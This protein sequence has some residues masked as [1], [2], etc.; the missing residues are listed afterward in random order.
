MVHHRIPFRFLLLAA[1]GAALPLQAHAD[2]PDSKLK[3]SG[4]LSIVGGRIVGSS[5]G[6][7]YVG[8][9]AID[10]KL[11]PCY[12]ADWSYAGAYRKT[13]SLEPETRAGIQLK[14]TVS[15]DLNLVTQIVT[16]ATDPKPSVQ[17]AYGSYAI[18]KQWEV[19]LGRKRIPLYFYS[20][21]QDVGVAYPW[22]GVPPELYGWEVTNYNGAS[23]RFKTSLG[24]TNIS[25]S[26]FAG[27]ETVKDALY[28]RLYYDSPTKVSWSKLVGGD[29]EVVH[30]VLTTR[31]VYM[32]SDVRTIN[33]HEALDD[34]AALKAYGLAANLDFEDWFV[35]AELTQ[36]TRDFD[37]GYKVTAPAFTVG[38]GYRW[39]N[40]TPFINVARY[41]EKSSDLAVYAPQSYDRAS[42]T[43]RYD[44]DARSAL[45]FQVDRNKD[46][47]RNF[48]G[49]TTILRLAY[50]RLF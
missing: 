26:M 42:L 5:L 37:S 30:G 3:V 21:Y 23:V 12:T 1:L 11:C 41:K 20:D 17:W 46:V 15:R 13:S 29:V 2:D 9:E 36:L 6:A 45:K 14:Y 16:R 25:A 39:G 44:V 32:Q 47:T 34:T 19:Q 24:D 4:F 35:L 27:R 40:W 7:D 28:M 49:N 33:P 22:V 8:P 43:L 38:A 10:G 31:A 50:D 18:D 48:G